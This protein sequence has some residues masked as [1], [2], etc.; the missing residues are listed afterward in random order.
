MRS[1]PIRILIVAVIVC[2]VSF[3]AF[4]EEKQEAQTDPTATNMSALYPTVEEVLPALPVAPKNMDDAK[5]VAEYMTAVDTY[6]KSVQKYVDGTTNDLNQIV[7]QRNIAVQNA[8]KA[9]E[10]YNGFFDAHAKK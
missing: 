2:T 7:E 4:A 10:E 1:N 5:A 9:I 6:I 3:L 8:N